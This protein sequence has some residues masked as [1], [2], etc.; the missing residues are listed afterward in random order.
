MTASGAVFCSG[1][2]TQLGLLGDLVKTRRYYRQDAVSLFFYES[3]GNETTRMQN[4]EMI[5]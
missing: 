3:K 4:Q 5:N 1:A 2:L